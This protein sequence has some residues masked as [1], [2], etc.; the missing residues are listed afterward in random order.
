MT[1]IRVDDPVTFLH[2]DRWLFG[3]VTAVDG[4]ELEVL[5][6]VQPTVPALAWK[7]Q[8]RDAFKLVPE[9]EPDA[10]PEATPVGS[11]YTPQALRALAAELRVQARAASLEVLKH[12]LASRRDPDPMVRALAA[13]RKSI[14]R[15]RTMR[16]A[17]WSGLLE[18]NADKVEEA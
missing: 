5:I 15:C 2:E 16:F 11:P 9:R 3:T 18:M 4:G 13:A 12:E 1:D 10:K 17:Q 8:A 6:A 7:V 14:E